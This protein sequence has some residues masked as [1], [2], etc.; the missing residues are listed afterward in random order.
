MIKLKHA[1]FRKAINLGRGTMAEYVETHDINPNVRDLKRWCKSLLF[2]ADARLIH[3]VTGLEGMHPVV[4]VPLEGV[5]DF[6]LE[7]CSSLLAEKPAE[8]KRAD[9]KGTLTAR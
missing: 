6:S 8:A 3:V 4:S 5:S 9:G 7:D 2:D 1:R